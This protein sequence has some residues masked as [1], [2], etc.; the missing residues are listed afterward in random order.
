MAEQT[1]DEE[2]FDGE[3]VFDE[4]CEDDFSVVP[5]PVN[6]GFPCTWSG[7]ADCIASGPTTLHRPTLQY[8]QEFALLHGSLRPAYCDLVRPCTLSEEH[9]SVQLPILLQ[10][11]RAWR[12]QQDRVAEALSPAT[13]SLPLSLSF[14]A[15]TSSLKA[16][17]IARA[18]LRQGCC[19]GPD[20]FL[21]CKQAAFFLVCALHIQAR[22]LIF[23]GL[24]HPELFPVE[25]RL[26]E[27]PAQAPCRLDARA[28]AKHI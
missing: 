1:T 17:E 14:P 4:V 10:Q 19:N 22:A 8:S 16:L 25:E 7:L 5:G 6:P 26:L 23:F 27:S 24:V 18:W 15:T 3:S 9:L 11:V 21:D 13:A 28:P 2:D 20:G 12:R